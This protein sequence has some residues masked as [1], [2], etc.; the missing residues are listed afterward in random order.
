MD[1]QA[2]ALLGSISVHTTSGRGRSADEI[3]E[4]AVQ[5]IIFVGGKSDPVVTAQAEAF[6]DQI[7]HVLVNTVIEAQKTERT[8]I[9]AELERQGRRD[10]A[11]IIRSL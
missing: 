1:N 7:K 6:K 3:A 11:D 8:N 5:R 9:C 4:R 10:L 2:A